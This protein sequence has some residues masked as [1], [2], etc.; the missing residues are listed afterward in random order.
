MR[1]D[2]SRGFCL[3][4]FETALLAAQAGITE[5]G[6]EKGEWKRAKKA[7]VVMLGFGTAERA[8]LLIS[9]LC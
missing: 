2:Q 1:G 3:Q 9:M 5:D 4:Q 6:D 8:E 7:C